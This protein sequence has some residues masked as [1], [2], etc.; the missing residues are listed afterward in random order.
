MSKKII[1]LIALAI[2][3]PLAYLIIAP[4]FR[5]SE[6]NT[7][8]TENG[9]QE[10][11]DNLAIMSEER[12]SEFVQ[13]VARAAS[14]VIALDED[15]PAGKRIAEG[16]LASRAQSAS[17]KVM[18]LETNGQRTLRLQDFQIANGPGLHVYLATELSSRDFVDLGAIKA[19]Q[20]N[21]NYDV[22]DN[23]DLNKYDKVLVWCVPFGVIFS[24]ADLEPEK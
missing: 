21:V 5:D 6:R 23:V 17:G 19:T 9:Q 8:R 3:V 20:G 7:G 15:R 1:I 18:V 14:E 10:I 13:E 12:R 11:K 16:R 22:P 24:Y 2:F 4:L